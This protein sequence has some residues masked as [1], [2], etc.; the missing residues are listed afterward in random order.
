MNL[1]SLY[2][3]DGVSCTE[4]FIKKTFNITITRKSVITA[5]VYQL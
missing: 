5:R 3:D 2:K 1:L 4:Q